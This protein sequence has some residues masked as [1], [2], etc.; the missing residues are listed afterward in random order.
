[1]LILTV[2]RIYSKI[3]K[4]RP[5]FLTVRVVRSFVLCRVSK[6]TFDLETHFP[7]RLINLK[8]TLLSRV[9]GVMFLK[10]FDTKVMK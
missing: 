2:E 5:L 4:I 8:T 1:M 10:T 7:E 6:S 3:L 9:V